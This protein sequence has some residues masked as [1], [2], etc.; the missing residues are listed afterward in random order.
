MTE[1]NRNQPRE[2]CDTTTYP[3]TLAE[4]LLL[5]LFQPSTGTFAGENTLPYALG[6]AVLSDLALAGQVETTEAKPAGTVIRVVADAEPGDPLTRPGWQYIERKPRTAQAIIA[7]IGPELREETIRRLV[8]RGDL[9][10]RK[11]KTLGVFSSTEISEGDTGRRSELLEA[12]RNAL[13]SGG[14]AEP[15]LAALCGLVFGSGMM[16][17]LD[18]D[19]PWRSDTIAAAEAHLQGDWGAGAAAQAVARTI[20]SGVIN[21]LIAAGVLFP[22]VR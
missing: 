22:T 14:A 17:Q 10:E 1:Q 7:A 2:N 18:P 4:D 21:S 6:G 15:R 11:G 13:V 16:P 8:D 19:I 12:V 5:L 20:A 9:I 3:P